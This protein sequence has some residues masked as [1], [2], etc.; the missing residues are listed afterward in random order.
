M[1]DSESHVKSLAV[2]LSGGGHRATLFVL[3]ALMYLVDA[4]ANADVT[5]IASVSGGSLTNGFVGQTLNFRETDGAEFRARVASPLATQ[6]AKHG[7]LFAPLLSKLYLA[8]LIVGALI[9]LAIPAFVPDHCYLCLEFPLLAYFHCY[10]CLILFLVGLMLWGLLLGFRGRICARSFKTT[11]FSPNGRETLLSDVKKAGLD[12]VICSTEF[13]S[14]EQMYF[15]GDFV[16]SFALGCGVP[17]E[18]SLADAVQASA[19][20]PGGFP[21][22]SLPT[23]QHKFSGAPPADKGGPPEPPTQMILT[24]GGVYD[25]MGEQWARGFTDRIKRCDQLDNGRKAPNQLV[26]VNASARIPWDPYRRR[27]IPLLAE[28]MALLRVLDILY[29]NTTNVRRQDIVE[30]FDPEHPDKPCALP[31][32]LVQISQ[33]PFSVAR[34]FAFRETPNP[35]TVRANEVL[36]L[37]KQG[38]TRE[39]W[40]KIA[41]ENSAVSTNLSK[42]GDEVT[43]RLIY[44][45]Y[46]V[47]MCNLHVLFSDFPLVPDGLN[48]ANFRQL[49]K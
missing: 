24:D 43:T 9:V 39:E 33:S 16:Y 32:G 26:V 38:P 4:K 23:K 35:V 1:N 17:A 8:V 3:G 10:L 13:R 22:A 27:L 29:I 47:T 44:Q 14:S 5:S 11:L 31:G 6:I 25:N 45:G 37:L 34:K 15:G 30:G 28:V 21:P 36:E 7:T 42:L 46:V 20:F 18:L 2:A 41:A 48:I 49:I 19:A 12:H 40:E